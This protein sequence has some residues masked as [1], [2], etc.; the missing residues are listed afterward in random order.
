MMPRSSSL[1]NQILLLN[2]WEQLIKLGRKW[3]EKI[4]ECPN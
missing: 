3:Q 4:A 2:D 1:S